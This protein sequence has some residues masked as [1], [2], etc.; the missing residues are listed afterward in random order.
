MNLW[1]IIHSTSI[2]AQFA[3]ISKYYN[4][5]Y[6]WNATDPTSTSKEALQNR[7]HYDSERSVSTFQVQPWRY[8]MGT[9]KSSK[10]QMQQNTTSLSIGN[11][12]CI[13]TLFT[14]LVYYARGA[15]IWLINNV[16]LTLCLLSSFLFQLDMEYVKWEHHGQ[17]DL[18]MWHSSQLGQ[19][20]PTHT[21]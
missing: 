3:F 13:N 14:I 6:G 9:L 19:E 10:S 2:H 1:Y 11:Y 12:R 4:S 18:N 21:G 8:A 15:L 5:C 16:K 20:E 17:M 7:T